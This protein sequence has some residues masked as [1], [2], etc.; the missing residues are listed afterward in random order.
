MI[1]M[2]RDKLPFLTIS[3]IIIA[4]DQ[5]SKIW[6]IKNIALFGSIDIIQG[7]FRL[8]HIRNTGAVWGLLDRNS[9]TITLIL[10]FFSIAAFLVMLWLFHKTDR[11]CR[12]DLIALSLIMGGALGNIIDRLRYGYVVDFI[13]LYHKNYHFPTFNIADSALTVG[14]T[15]LI[16][17]I[18]FKRCPP[19]KSPFRG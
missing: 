13:E 9:S 6:V 10:A 3:L 7:F 14:V 16:V 18:L 1:I 8:F 2:Q 5:L 4:L 19:G 11:S 15:L 12:L 17:S